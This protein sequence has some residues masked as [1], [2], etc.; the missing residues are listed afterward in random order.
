LGNK[1]FSLGFVYNLLSYSD[2][3]S[4][5]STTT[6]DL[7]SSISLGVIKRFSDFLSF[8]TVFKND[9]FSRANTSFLDNS[10]IRAGI[11]IKL[12]IKK[13]SIFGDSYF[14][15][16]SSIYN[17]Y[18][19][20]IKLNIINGLE[21]S[22]FYSGFFKFP[23]YGSAGLSIS[24]NTAK[25]GIGMDQIYSR[26]ENT[27]RDPL[28]MFSAS[29]TYEN[30]KSIIPESNKNLELKV[31]G[32]VQDYY[33]SPVL[34]GLLGNE[35][36]SVHQMINEIDKA[37]GDEN[38]K[39][40]LLYLDPF[41]SGGRFG[42]TATMEELGDAIKRFRNKGKK[43][44]AYLGQGASIEEYYTATFCDKIVIPREA[45]LFYGLSTDVIN[46]RGF[47]KKFGIDLETFSAGKYKLT[48]QGLLDSTTEAGKEVINRALDVIYEEMLAR[49]KVGRNV[50]ISDELKRD[51]SRPLNAFELKDRRLID[52]I[53]WY[54]DA[55]DVLA[56]LTGTDKIF[57]GYSEN[58]WSNDWSAP[59]E[60]AV[61]GIYGGITTG[62][63][64]APPLINLPVPIPFVTPGR[65]TGSQTIL[66][67]LTNAFSNPKVKAVILRIDSG[68]GSAL[69]SAEMYDAIKRLK[70]KYRKPFVVSMGDVA[71]SGG[72]YVSAYGDRI[73]SGKST[74]TGSIGV[75]ASYPKLD[76]LMKDL[77]IK[78][79]V[80]KRGENSDIYSPYANF[81]EE[82]RE[83][84]IRNI[85]FTYDQFINSV[86]EGRKMSKESVDSVAQGRVWMGKDA[87]DK[88]L[89]DEIG[90]LYNAVEYARQHT[91][92]SRDKLR[93]VYYPVAGS[94]EMSDL[95]SKNASNLITDGLLDFLGLK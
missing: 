10:S 16:G 18:K 69:A 2:G 72:Y 7:Y 95:I 94:D 6:S 34:F 15:F 93:L 53:G 48:F 50:I 56:A 35:K 9:L 29:Y 4:F 31:K 17:S 66:K 20:G 65:T 30:R 45:N 90:G 46:Y 14:N 60:I 28:S 33:Q 62:E 59:D 84:I 78:A 79:E 8:S 32:S 70:K 77:R 58:E 51:L 24:V 55:K 71:A 57:T 64:S 86:A 54:D 76:S 42:V 82:E 68:G 74:V 89:T 13:L 92:L 87:L 26:Y 67:Q 40:M 52:E 75:L 25:I 38:I 12:L 85:L 49:V 81:S 61:I 73:F 27:Y 3:N 19:T 39:G 41:T 21:A 47:L 83:I 43:T 1:S 22:G 36:R 44:V 80:F 37:A 11:G 91:G 23:K 88:K 5:I 63:S